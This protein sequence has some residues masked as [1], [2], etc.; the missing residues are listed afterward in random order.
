MQSCTSEISPDILQATA[1][2][3]SVANNDLAS[4]IMCLPATVDLIDIDQQITKQDH[5]ALNTIT[6]RD[7]L[8]AQ[9]H[10]LVI[11]PALRFK[12]NGTKP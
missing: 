6:P 11:A 9:Q 8:Q 1:A 10:D 12:P 7:I 4:W 5:S 2:A 3:M